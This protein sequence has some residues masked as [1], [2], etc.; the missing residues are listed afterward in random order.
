[1]RKL[2]EVPDDVETRLWKLSR[3]GSFERLR[4]LGET[5]MEAGLKLSSA[6]PDCTLA[7]LEKKIDGKWERTSEIDSLVS[8]LVEKE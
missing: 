4:D 7:V 6:A 5:V 1:M 2:F 3:N 8:E